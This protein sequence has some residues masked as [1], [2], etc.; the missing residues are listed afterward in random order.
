MNTFSR[1]LK[2]LQKTEQ[3]V[4]K[5]ELSMSKVELAAVDDIESQLRIL[6]RLFEESAS[7]GL[8]VKSLVDEAE[9]LEERMD[10]A[11]LEINNMA[12]K[13]ST[14]NNKL[15]QFYKDQQSKEKELK[16]D[17]EIFESD[18]KTFKDDL[19]DLQ[20]EQ[21]SVINA[22]D[23]DIKNLKNIESDLLKTIQKTESILKEIAK[24]A[25]DLGVKPNQLPAYT[26]GENKLK[27]AQKQLN[28]IKQDIKIAQASF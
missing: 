4:K 7:R 17:I 26:K 5:T 8:M 24:A 27:E 15:Q 19:V 3:L 21:N 25:S 16:R 28:M 13:V 20:N 14:A 23:R 6:D 18:L 2:Q 12:E 9:D 10:D 22:I 11:G 1:V